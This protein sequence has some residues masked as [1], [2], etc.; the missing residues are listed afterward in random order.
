MDNREKCNIANNKNIKLI[1]EIIDKYYPDSSS[2]STNSYSD[3]SDNSDNS[4]CSDDSEE[5][6][7]YKMP[8]ESYEKIEK[9]DKIYGPFSSTWIHSEQQCDDKIINDRLTKQFNKLR[10]I[11]SPEQRSDEWFSLRRNAIT[12]SDGAAALGKSKYD[13]QYQFILKKVNPP[14]FR[15]N[16]FCYHGKKYEEIATMIYSYRMN[17]IVEEFGLIIHPKYSYIGASPDGICNGYRCDNKHRT[18]VVGRML[19]IKCPFSRK[20]LTEGKIK[21]EICPLHYWIQVQLQLECCEL[22]ECDFW[23]CSIEEYQNREEFIKDTD[24]LEPFRSLEFGFEKGCVI[25]ILPKKKCKYASKLSSNYSEVVYSEAK[26]IYP[27]S[28]EMTPNECDMW[29]SKTLFELGN[30]HPKYYFDKIKYWKLKES[31]NDT[32]KRDIEWFNENLSTMTTVWNYVEFL[33]DREDV[34]RKINKYVEKMKT[35]YN[36]YRD[37]EKI[38][39]KVMN[40]IKQLYEKYSS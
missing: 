2:Y 18:N 37:S 28:I 13:P 27:P 6:S 39:E 5:E 17:A 29:I 8:K 32:I 22:D 15:S 34:V 10:L 35:R 38:N 25:Q 19:E 14:E 3:N 16:K 20:I 24:K 1:S 4:N 9:T 33:R 21:G 36:L 7:R 12:A 31:H 26:F 30:T 11:V 40:Y 23:Q